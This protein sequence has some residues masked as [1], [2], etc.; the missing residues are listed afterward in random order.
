M[1]LPKTSE[2][3]YGDLRA[4]LVRFKNATPLDQQKM[5]KET[6][7]SL[8]A[9]GAA[10]DGK[11]QA[12]EAYRR[13]AYAATLINYAN[14]LRRIQTGEFF[15]ILIDFKMVALFKTE[16]FAEL[17]D[18]FEFHA[19]APQMKL[20]QPIAAIPSRIWHLFRDAQK[21]KL[22]LENKSDRFHLDELDIDAPP[23]ADQLYPLSIQMLGKYEN[24]AVDR[25]W[26]SV[27]GEYTFAANFGV[28]LLPG[29]GMIEIDLGKTIEKIG[30]AHV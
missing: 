28:F 21:E 29:G 27:N 17:N 5:L 3:M 2:P 15:D 20:K 24:E 19:Q 4:E 7:S 26:G 6:I 30:R 23:P 25:V 14:A 22:R 13:L 10:I 16:Q 9:L 12:I 8:S 11:V 1:P 18:Y